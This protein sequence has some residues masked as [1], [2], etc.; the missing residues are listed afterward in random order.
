MQL[1][2][3]SGEI[4]EIVELR[5]DD[6]VPQNV[7]YTPASDRTEIY[8]DEMNLFGGD[9]SD[10]GVRGH[11]YV[12]RGTATQQPDDY[13]EAQ[14]GE[15]LPAWRRVSHAVFRHV[16]LG[17]SPYIKAV[18]AVVRRCPNALGLTGGAE[19]IGGDANPAAMIYDLLTSSPAEN[20][21]GLP[22]GFLDLD[23]FRAVGQ[24]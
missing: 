12:Y 10:G 1:V 13:L 5:F 24:T 9:E 6:R 4:D 8:V 16:Y 7:S 14:I 2:L 20:G 21:L 15:A 23:A 11:I 17:T 3:C 18:S 22:Q 19:N